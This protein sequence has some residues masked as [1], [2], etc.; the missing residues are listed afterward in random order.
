MKIRTDFVTNSSSS[1]F[2]TLTVALKNGK[3]IDW[4]GEDG[5]TPI[6]L[7]PSKAKK[8]LSEIKNIEEL[9]LFIK[10]CALEYMDEEEVADI[11]NGRC[12][13]FEASIKGISGLEEVS[14]FSL[15]WGEYMSDQGMHPAEG[16][17]GE[18]LVYD[19]KTKICKTKRTP[20]KEFVKDMIDIYGDMFD[21]ED[22]F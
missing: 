17:E 11:F 13:E 15:S 5:E 1:S 7:I 18:S 3:T 10:K 9:I 12:K 22:F 14:K 16:C 4:Y 2:C 20:D 19:F 21:E 8:M 6:F